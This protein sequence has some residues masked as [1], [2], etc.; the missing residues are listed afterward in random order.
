M[1]KHNV[2][3]IAM[4]SAK[5]RLRCDLEEL[6]SYGKVAKKYDV[7]K[8]IIWKICNDPLFVPG[9]PTRRKLG[10]VADKK[11]Y[12][13]VCRDAEEKKAVLQFRDERRLNDTP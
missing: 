1:V 3:Q 5:Y 10:I 7:N 4:N 9:A 2:Y 11:Q 8:A 12:N 6:G 13:V